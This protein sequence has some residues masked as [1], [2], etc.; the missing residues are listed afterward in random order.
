MLELLQVLWSRRIAIIVVT[1]IAALGGVFYAFNAQVWYRAEVVVA[2]SSSKSLPGSLGQL[3]GLAGLAGINIGAD[4]SSQI[5]IAVLRSRDFVR[6]FIESRDLTSVL[7]SDQWDSVAKTWREKNPAKQP[8]IRDAVEFFDRRVRRVTED[9]KKGLITLS[10]L[11]PDARVGAE[12][13]N[14]MIDSV[15]DRLRSNAL[16]EAEQNI[17]YLQTEISS[18]KVIALQQPLARLLETEM[19]KVLTARGSREYAF[20]VIDR[21]VAAKRP[22][23]PQRLLL[24]L[25]SAMTGFFLAAIAV[26][27]RARFWLH[28]HL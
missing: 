14:G 22:A 9:D 17:Q 23:S 3:G 7:L 2:H 6:E 25:A 24:I 12:W 11:W 4:S 8:D 13:A 16:A 21:A 26:L 15:N 20:R 18:A 1:V 19:Q 27:L 28:P 10:V 5:P